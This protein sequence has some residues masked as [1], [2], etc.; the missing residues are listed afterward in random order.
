MTTNGK[1]AE[2]RDELVR[3]DTVLAV[4]EQD[5]TSYLAPVP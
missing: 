3:I 2:L 5:E 1:S 4:T